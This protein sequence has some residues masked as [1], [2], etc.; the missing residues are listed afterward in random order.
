MRTKACGVAGL[1][2]AVAL[3]VGWALAQ[4]AENPVEPETLLPASAAIYFSCDGVDSH[5]AAWEQTAA[6]ES[7]VASG[8]VDG[9]KKF[10]AAL[11]TAVQQDPQARPVY[12]LATSAADTVW[13]Q[14]VSVAVSGSLSSPPF[15]VIVVHEGAPLRNPL[16]QLVQQAPE[17]NLSQSMVSG[18][19][20]ATVAIPGSP[21]EVAWWS[22]GGHLVVA[23]GIQPVRQAMAVAAGEQPSI[24]THRLWS[25]YDGSNV[26]FEQTSVGWVDFQALQES[27]GG[28]P[29]PF[30]VEEGQQ[31]V[32]VRQLLEALGLSSLQ[33]I[34]C[35]SGLEG[36]SCRTKTTVVAP[37]P[38]SGLL[39]LGDQQPITLEDLPPL[40]Q[41]LSSMGAASF[42]TAA[43]AQTIV[44]TIRGVMLFGPP[45]ARQQFDDGLAQINGAVGLNLQQDLLDPLGHVHTFYA[46]SG[47]GL[48]G[49]GFAYVASVDDAG[50]LRQSVDH[51]LGRA[52]AESDGKLSVQRVTK[53]GRELVLLQI[54]E[55]PVTPALCVDDNWLCV[56]VNPQI[57]ESFLRRLDGSMPR[58][59]PDEAATALLADMPQ[60]FISLTLSDP[61]PGYRMVL[62]W[63]P[64]MVGMAVTQLQQENVLER[65]ERLDFNASDIPPAELVTRPLHLN[66]RMQTASAEGFEAHSKSSLAGIPLVGGGGGPGLATSGVAIALLLP[67]VQQAREAARRT[68]SQNN[69]KQIG[70]ALHNYHNVFNHFPEGTIPN[71]QLAPDKRLSWLVNVLPY[72][73]QAPLYN[74]ID[75]TAGWQADVNSQFVETSVPVFINPSIGTGPGAN[76]SHYAGCA[77]VGEDGPTLPAGHQR[78]GIFGYDRF[79]RVRDITDG[80]SNTIMVFEVQEGLGPWAQGGKTS[81]RSLAQ[82]PYIHGPDGIGGRHAGGAFV[83]MGDASA[84]F[85]SENIDPTLMKALATQAG[86]ETVGEF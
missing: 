57:V 40:P 65:G 60:E 55:S 28:I 47:E 56:G 69:L 21:A 5:R 4:Q 16:T 8:L 38:R 3:S 85:V 43:A 48:F 64:L 78:A 73:E 70:L 63:V 42:D 77:G 67:A 35:Q 19:S 36:R 14:G 2:T 29:L 27:F 45:Q 6:Y 58:W 32:Q 37:G 15:G 23:V 13:Q 18:R 7:L 41:Q 61:R 53:S 12:E 10:L 79:S 83:L 34:A 86:G 75:K 30:P 81:V 62:N 49:L 74:A 44:N 31:P 52:V 33:E 50:R 82:E 1:L 84:R 54:A 68:Q 51:L 66:I 20:V 26:G 80:T 17:V 9:V 25:K 46:D 71:D 72:L 39:A 76:F 24:T 22:E 59:Q 11:S